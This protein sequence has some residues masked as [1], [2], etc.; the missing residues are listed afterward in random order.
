MLKIYDFKCSH[1]GA[2]FEKMVKG[3]PETIDC[4]NCDKSAKRQMSTPNLTAFPGSYNYE[5]KRKE[6]AIKQQRQHGTT[7]SR[8]TWS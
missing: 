4:I 6:D 1:C 7:K 2:E 8:T 3:T 5:V